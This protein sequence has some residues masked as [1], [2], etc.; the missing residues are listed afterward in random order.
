MPFLCL[1]SDVAAAA[2]PIR[3]GDTPPRSQ[4]FLYNF[5]SALS[6]VL[7]TIMIL[8]LGDKL[9]EAQTSVILLIGAGSFIFIALSELLPEALAVAGAVSD[10]GSVTVTL[11]QLRKLASFFLGA[12][13]IGVPL[14]FDQ[15]CSADGHDH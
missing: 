2:P 9:T 4:A 11:S 14:L 6:A 3:R 8:S 10:R 13:L 12:F 7:G 15:H 5:L 1:P